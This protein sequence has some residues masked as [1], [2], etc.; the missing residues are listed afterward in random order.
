MEFHVSA[1]LLW[2]G[3][4]VPLVFEWFE[5]ATPKDCQ[6]GWLYSFPSTE[7]KTLL[8]NM[9]MHSFR[10]WVSSKGP[11]KSFDFR[12][13]SLPLNASLTLLATALRGLTHFYK[14]QWKD[15]SKLIVSLVHQ[16][17]IHCKNIVVLVV[18]SLWLLLWRQWRGKIYRWKLKLTLYC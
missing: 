4:K 7:T 14:W 1:L 16:I 6:S 8:E 18:S 11:F 3:R 12:V 9:E 15:P 5:R 13:T 17:S 2:A 10:G